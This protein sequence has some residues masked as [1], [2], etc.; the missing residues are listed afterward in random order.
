MLFKVKSTE[1]VWSHKQRE[2]K[3]VVASLKISLRELKETKKVS[4]W[5]G[6]ADTLGFTD[7]KSVTR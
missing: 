6:C 3:S 4:A 5:Q 7:T 2:E 1:K